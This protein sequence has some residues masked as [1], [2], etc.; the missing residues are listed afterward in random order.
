MNILEN[1]KTK[2]IADDKPTLKRW[3]LELARDILIPA[4][5]AYFLFGIV[6][7]VV[8]VNGPSMNPT[9]NNGDLLV[10]RHVGATIGRG[11]IVVVKKDAPVLFE[12][13]IIKRVIATG[14]DSLDID[15]STGAVLLNGKE[16]NELYINEATMTDLGIEFPVVVP[17]GCYFVMGDNRNNSLD[18]RHPEIGFITRDEVFGDILFSISSFS[19]PTDY[20]NVYKEGSEL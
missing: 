11:D 14:G 19:A 8:I 13:Y 5:V 17:D 2:E 3:L 16:L 6:F 18:S 9:L 7:R 10:M 1:I 20:S 4:L 12:K 15:Y